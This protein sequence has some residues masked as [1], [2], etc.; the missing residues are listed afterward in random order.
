[1]KLDLVGLSRKLSAVVLLV[2]SLGPGVVL[3]QSVGSEMAGERKRPED[4]ALYEP[5]KTGDW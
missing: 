2:V 3:A 5:S 4:L 1:M